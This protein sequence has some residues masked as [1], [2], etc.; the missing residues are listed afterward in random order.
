MNPFKPRYHF[1]ADG[2]W[3]NDPNGL[4]QLGDHYHLFFQSHPHSSHW[5]EIGWGHASSTDLLNWQLH[6]PALS[7]R[8]NVMIFSGSAVFDQHNVSRLGSIEQP[9]LLAFYT[10]A[11]YHWC[12]DGSM[13]MLN[14]TQC[15]AASTDQGMTWTPYRHNPLLDLGL[16]DFRDPK[17]FPYKDHWIMAVALST[18]HCI[19]FY[20]SQDLLEWR[21]LSEFS[22]PSLARGQWE[23]P[24]LFPLTYQ[25][26]TRW[27]LIMGISEDGSTFGSNTHYF[28]GHFDG[29]SFTLDPASMQGQPSIPLDYG[30]DYFAAQTFAN[31][32]QNGSNNVMIG[33]MS[34]WLYARQMRS[35]L[36]PCL[37]AIPRQVSLRPKADG[38][39]MHQQ[40][41]SQLLQR[42]R[43]VYSLSTPLA[44]A[45]EPLLVQGLAT[46]L[47]IEFSLSLGAHSVWEMQWVFTDGTTLTFM[48]D[49][50]ERVLSVNRSSLSAEVD[51]FAALQRLTLGSHYDQLS[52]RILFDRST[53]E[54]FVA[55]GEY[56][57]SIR[58]FPSTATFDLAMR[59]PEGHAGLISGEIWQLLEPEEK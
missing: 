54:V 13:R 36:L 59:S 53:L 58:V 50:R 42:R 35:H 3:M 30:Q 41:V 31:T 19:R 37:Q 51:G 5:G 28:V 57:M 29:R 15:V 52:L 24:D 4:I 8:E 55:E 38:F 18:A 11:H 56:V 22:E 47:D 2:T 6:P 1:D 20:Q 17:V 32:P 49:M 26:E 33:W 27:I 45:D 44:L 7:P 40:P 23:C 10:E 25:G 16:A 39:R 48:L 34:N 9:P 12:D 21:M 46:V 43:P 14:Q